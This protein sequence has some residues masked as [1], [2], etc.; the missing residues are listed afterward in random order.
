[1]L[2]HLILGRAVLGNANVDLEKA[3]LHNCQVKSVS[4]RVRGWA[5]ACRERGFGWMTSTSADPHFGDED[6]KRN[7]S[8]Q[9]VA[10]DGGQL[11]HRRSSHRSGAPRIH[12]EM[13]N[14]VSKSALIVPFPGGV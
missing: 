11:G 10:I 13:R 3:A 5:Q 1:M 8:G 2:N 12:R 14:R 7:V 6:E 4:S 9:V